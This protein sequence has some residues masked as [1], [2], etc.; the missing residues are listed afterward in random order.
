L[1]YA[2]STTKAFCAASASLLVDDDEKH[3]N[4][5]WET[6]ISQLIRDDFVLPDPYWT[7]HITLEDALSHRTGFPTH[8]KCC[9]GTGSSVR[10]N[11]RKLLH[12]PASREPR[13]VS[14]YCN[15]MFVAVSHAIEVVTGEYLGNF[16]ARRIWKPLGMTSTY[17]SLGDAKKSRTPFAEGYY[18]DKEKEEHVVVPYLDLSEVSG[19][20]CNI[21]TVIDYSKWIRA[22]INMDGPISQ[23]GHEALVKPLIAFDYGYPASFPTVFYGLGWM[24][25]Y[26]QGEKVIFHP[27]GI[28]GFSAMVVYLPQRAWGC[29]MMS[30]SNYAA[31]ALEKL[32]WFLIDELLEVPE[33]KR[34][35]WDEW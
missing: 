26:Y 25:L 3:K 24:M 21:S 35:D 32:V 31:P 28:I 34:V 22:M 5:Q 10:E 20:G 11:V 14:Q 19:G 13:T 16:L 23:K 1:F 8:N 18:W 12:I 33:T 2:G 27:G 17:F 4:L 7:E 6:P 29:V 9:I 30:N 15:I